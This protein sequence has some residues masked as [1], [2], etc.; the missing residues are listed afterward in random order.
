[1]VASHSRSIALVSRPALDV[2]RVAR[3]LAVAD[4]A[5]DLVDL[6]RRREDAGLGP[7]LDRPA[8][9]AVRRQPQRPLVGRGIAGEEGAVGA[10]QARREG[11][12]AAEAGVK[13][14]DLARQ[15]RHGSDAG[16]AALRRRPAAADVEEEDRRD[17]RHQDVADIGAGV[18]GDVDL[19][20]VAVREV[21]AARRRQVGGR[22]QETAVAVEDQ[23]GA[24]LGQPVMQA[25][26]AGVER[27]LAGADRLVGEPAQRL[28]RGLDCEVDGLEDLE[29][30]LLE[31]VERALDALVSAGP[32]GAVARDA[33]IAEERERKHHRGGDEPTQDADRRG[34]VARCHPGRGAPLAPGRIVPWGRVDCNR[35][36][37]GEGRDAAFMRPL[38]T[39]RHFRIDP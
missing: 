26:E 17:A 4:P 18:A 9:D 35:C 22:D 39:G 20:V 28:G 31:H 30:V 13:G 34:A 5:P 12:A 21:D 15:H 7:G 25:L 38:R 6:R 32:G 24:D 11:E 37:A 14:L 33:R 19:E 8:E 1:M 36:G 16:K 2:D 3:Q 29:G 23:D 10:D 27:R